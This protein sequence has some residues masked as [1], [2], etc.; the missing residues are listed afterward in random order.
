MYSYNLL[1]MRK[2]NIVRRAKSATFDPGEWLLL[3]NSGSRSNCSVPDVKLD[4]KSFRKTGPLNFRQA[5]NPN[6]SAILHEIF[7]IVLGHY[8]PC[9]GFYRNSPYQD[10]YNFRLV[11]KAF[12]TASKPLFEKSFF[13]TRQGTVGNQSLQPLLSLSKTRLNE[14]VKGVVLN[15][16]PTD[17][18]PRCSP[19]YHCD[20]EKLSRTLSAYW[21]ESK[22][23]NWLA[24]INDKVSSSDIVD[25]LAEILERLPNLESICVNAYSFN[26]F[27]C[28]SRRNYITIVAQNRGS[29][30]L[31]VADN[32]VAIHNLAGDR[33]GYHQLLRVWNRCLRACYRAFQKVATLNLQR[34]QLRVP[35]DMFR[36]GSPPFP[37]D[38]FLQTSTNH[39]SAQPWYEDVQ[40]LSIT[41][42]V[43]ESAVPQQIGQLTQTNDRWISRLLSGMKNVKKLSIRS[44]DAELITNDPL[45]RS[46]QKSL[47]LFRTPTS[48][49]VDFEINTTKYHGFSEN[50]PWTWPNLH[51][52]SELTLCN[53]QVSHDGAV[54]FLNAYKNT[55]RTLRLG[56]VNYMY[57]QVESEGWFDF[58]LLAVTLEKRIQLLFT[59]STLLL[60][61]I[62]TCGKWRVTETY[63]PSH[64]RDY[65]SLKRWRDLSRSFKQSGLEKRIVS[66]EELLSVFDYHERLPKAPNNFLMNPHFELFDITKYSKS[67]LANNNLVIRCPLSDKI[68]IPTLEDE[69]ISN[70]RPAWRK[71]AIKVMGALKKKIDVSK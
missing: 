23:H 55:V 14:Y 51:C 60:S 12:R 3:L 63:S 66:P 30:G 52:L 41:I 50:P 1:S 34:F 47:V 57:S 20:P 22:Y 17:W 56:G 61:F 2:P 49:M 33:I 19:F 71:W 46:H 29:Q 36:F 9:G 6:F 53:V 44:T 18:R 10:V 59:T 27:F 58:I 11:C 69:I 62:W 67:D 37:R 25:T 32:R 54:A 13:E 5:N 39:C 42:I 4:M 15:L 21:D 64:E 38:V 40:E 26:E 70:K 68:F 65:I 45:D 24:D 48:N 16:F 8:T 31:N 28:A 7:K 35:Q 43:S